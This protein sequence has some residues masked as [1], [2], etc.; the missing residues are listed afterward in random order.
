MADMKKHLDLGCGQ[1]PRNPYDA[2][3]LY[4]VD[5]DPNIH[6]LGDNF[7]CVN[8]SIDPIPFPDAYFD[9]VS[10]FDFI[11]HI[12]RQAIDFQSKTT[13]LPFIELMNEIHRVLK[14]GGMFYAVTPAYPSDE[15]F[16][17]PTHVNFITGKTH[18]YFCDSN[19]NYGFK[20]NFKAVE[21]SWT[22]ISYAL[23]AKKNLLLHLKKIHK[24]YLKGGS[25][26]ILWQLKAIK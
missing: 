19:G 18:Q 3:T 10:G 14:P 7:K 24:K 26:H 21:V 20:G 13:R 8:L 11:E 12:P 22:N 6:L 23:K 25:S 16:Q 1:T 9:S 2:E 17:D 15:T 5:I 4:G